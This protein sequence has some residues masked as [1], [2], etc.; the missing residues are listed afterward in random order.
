MIT[1]EDND[2][3]IRPNRPLSKG[4]AVEIAARVERLQ[5]SALATGPPIDSPRSDAI[6]PRGTY[7]A[8]AGVNW[9]PVEWLKIQA[10]VVREWTDRPPT[11]VEEVFRTWHPVARGQVAW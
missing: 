4:G 6:I 10:N 2:S 8:T 9:Y 1:G 5:M 3:R 7:A 11:A